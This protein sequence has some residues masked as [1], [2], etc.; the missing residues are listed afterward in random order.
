MFLFSCE[1]VQKL[2]QFSGLKLML[3]IILNAILKLMLPVVLNATSLT[4]FLKN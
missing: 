1:R 3:P 2:S 4:S